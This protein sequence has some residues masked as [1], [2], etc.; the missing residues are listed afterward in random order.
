MDDEE[1]LPPAE[2]ARDRK[3]DRLMGAKARAGMRTGV[4]KLY[5]AIGDLQGRRAA[6]AREQLEATR[7]ADEERG[8]HGKG[9]RRDR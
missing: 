5:K 2:A 8:R 3:R 4:A 6:E 7:S 9:Q 1:E